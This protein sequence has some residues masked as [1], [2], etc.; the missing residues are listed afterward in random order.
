M[1]N[2]TKP[3]PSSYSNGAEAT[4]D[5]SINNTGTSYSLPGALWDDTVVTW[6]N[7]TYDWGV[8]IDE[9]NPVSYTNN[10]TGSASYT[11]D[12]K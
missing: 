7:A 4:A 6:A 3:S 1:P 8:F 9:T 11:N 12:S 2:D 5:S 10:T